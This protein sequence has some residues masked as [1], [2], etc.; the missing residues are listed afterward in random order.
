[1][2]P[3]GIV[4][5]S[6]KLIKEIPVDLRADL[7]ATPQDAA[8]KMGPS[9]LTASQTDALHVEPSKPR[10]MFASVAAAAAPQV[11]RK[12]KSLL[13]L[14]KRQRNQSNLLLRKR[15]QSNLRS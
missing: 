10:A 11:K 12:R 14:R 6:K 9:G 13:L 15:E 5:K 1:M 8:V 2:P 3:K 7:E 4:I